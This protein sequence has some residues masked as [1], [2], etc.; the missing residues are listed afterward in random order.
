MSKK[1][2]GNGRWESSRMMLPEHRE[3]Y[4]NRQNKQS[5]HMK[6]DLPSKE[7]ME[8]IRDSVLLPMILTIVDKNSTEISLSSY[9]LKTLYLKASQILMAEIHSDLSEIRKQLKAR[10][11]KVF[12]EEHIDSA[13]YYRFICRGYEDTFAIVRNV[14]RAEISVRIAKYIANMFRKNDN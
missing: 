6:P 4:L 13:M 5:E 3:Q 12:Q 7:E 1:L 10:N 11:I 9:S 2:E 8:W 14:A